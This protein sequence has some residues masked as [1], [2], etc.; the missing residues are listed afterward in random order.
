MS[1]MINPATT[2]TIMLVDDSTIVRRM[3]ETFFE[4]DDFIQ[5]I[6]SVENGSEALKTLD[7]QKPDLVILDIEMPE[8]DGL[9]ALPKILEK[10]PGT[11][12]V[13]CSSLT[14][15]GATISL[16]ALS[17]GAIEC[18]TKPTANTSNPNKF[19]DFRE[20]VLRTV[21]GLFPEKRRLASPHGQA[22][23]RKEKSESDTAKLLR[24]ASPPPAPAA[25]PP[26]PSANI[27]APLPT[28]L[29]AASQDSEKF[30]LYNNPRAYL[31]KPDIIAIGSSTGGPQALFEVL[32]HLRGVDVPI[33]I[34]Q[35]M[36]PTFT[37]LLA[38]HIH[39]NT[40]IPSH[41]AEGNMKLTGGHIYVAPG[42]FHLV[43][44]KKGDNSVV[45]KL[46]DGPQVNYCKP[47]VDV[48]FESL[49]KIYK[50]KVLGVIL[51]GMG[52]DG[53][54]GCQQLVQN[55][56]RVIAQNKETS[57]VWGMPRAVALA[58]ICCNVLPLKEI[59]PWIKKQ[60]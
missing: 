9:T 34:T 11:K 44:E 50:Q 8:M 59:G 26:T 13:M 53:Q 60:L 12:V 18:I 58:N 7:T 31:G 43:F 17:L 41:E 1:I 52:N 2:I 30:Q 32:N 3:I 42:G 48:M 39:Q 5:V 23:Q 28:P 45:T 4:T 16:K 54:Q 25:S 24:G 55:N 51:T 6:A 35:H 37:R 56:S 27:R 10:C 29:P 14:E 20:Q 46:D 33:V 15:R 57:V 40:G 19:G 38:T 49:A 21:K 36:P 22:L 47:S